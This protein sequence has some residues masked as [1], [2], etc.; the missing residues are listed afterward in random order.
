MDVPSPRRR[1]SDHMQTGGTLLLMLG[2]VP[3]GNLSD[4]ECRY[5]LIFQ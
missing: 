5:V 2:T 4:V 3:D 1:T